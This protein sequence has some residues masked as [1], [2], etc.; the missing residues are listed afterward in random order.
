MLPRW[1]RHVP[2]SAEAL[3]KAYTSRL[4]GNAERHGTL[5][6]RPICGM[7]E[8]LLATESMLS[9]MVRTV[10]END[11]VT[12]SPNPPATPPDLPVY[13]AVV[14]R[15]MQWDAL[16]WQVPSLSMAAQAFLLTI[17]FGPDTSRTSRLLASGLAVVAALLSLHLLVRHRQAEVTDAHWLAA[18]EQRHFGITAHGP[19]WRD[20][21][22]ATVIPGQL[23]VLARI[24][25]F[26]VWQAALSLFGVVGLIAFILAIFDIGSL[27]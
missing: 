25:A 15:R 19:E 14:A 13:Q 17:A 27:R 1:L 4:R 3:V 21:R 20:R 12:T 16:L 18:Y 6:A 10:R 9:V 26:P 2:V 22:N 5:M 8:C 7:S 23:G 24:P 11:P